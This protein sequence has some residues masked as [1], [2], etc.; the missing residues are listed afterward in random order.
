MPVFKI[1]NNGVS[2]YATALTD[3]SRAGVPVA[4]RNT[5]NRAAFDVKQVTMPYETDKT[6]IKRKPTFFK[7]TSSVN[8][9]TGLNTGSMKAEVGFI[10]PGDKKESGHATQDLE[11]QEYGGDIDKRAFQPEAR[12]RNGTGNVKQALLLAKLKS[13]I[14]DSDKRFFSTA[15]TNASRFIVSAL[16]AGK[17][18]FIIGTERN[19]KGNRALMQILSVKRKGR[20]TIVK[21]KAVYSVHGKRKAH[22]K[23][24]HFME[25][26]ADESADKMEGYFREEAEKFFRRMQMKQAFPAIKP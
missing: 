22:V 17:G 6:F 15:K 3:L 23:A 8:P 11:E 26:A 7:A 13:R 2:D 4:V 1:Y 10:A 24:T 25:K 12:A 9:A 16:F 18:S 14:V 19:S 21:S 20:N 5:L